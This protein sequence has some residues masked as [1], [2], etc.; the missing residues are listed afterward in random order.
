MKTYTHYDLTT[1]HALELRRNQYCD[2]CDLNDYSMRCVVPSMIV[3]NECWQR[4]PAAP[5]RPDFEVSG[6]IWPGKFLMMTLWLNGVNVETFCATEKK[7]GQ[8]AE[9]WEDEMRWANQ[10]RPHLQQL[11]CPRTVLLP[12]AEPDAPWSA[13]SHHHTI[14][15]DEVWPEIQRINTITMHYIQ[16]FMLGAGK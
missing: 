4:F 8:S 14:A 15:R 3:V 1:G 6:R 11:L 13:S 9:M 2:G 5:Q 12:S 7:G 16:A 10:N